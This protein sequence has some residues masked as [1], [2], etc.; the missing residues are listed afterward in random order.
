MPDK[1]FL[2]AADVVELLEVAKPTAYSI[3]RRLNKELENKGYITVSGKISTQYFFERFGIEEAQ[4][5]TA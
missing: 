3:I 1:L 2:T 4:T 5:Q